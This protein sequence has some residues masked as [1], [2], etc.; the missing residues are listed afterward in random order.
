MRC[1][2]VDLLP[3]PRR[4]TASRNRRCCGGS[5]GRRSTPSPAPTSTPRSGSSTPRPVSSR[6]P[7]VAAV[8][9]SSRRRSI[10]PC[11]RWRRTALHSMLGRRHWS[12]RCAPPGHVCSSRS[13]PPAPGKP[14]PCAPSPWPGPKTAV[15]CSAWPRRLPRP[16]SSPSKPASAP[17]PSPSSPGHCSTATCRTG[18]QR[19][20]RRPW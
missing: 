13:P 20:A 8:R 18:R 4:T 5:T 10:W 17:T 7:D 12:A 14:P 2:I 15:R 3:W 11:S 19:S 1:S 6:R 16:P 9:P